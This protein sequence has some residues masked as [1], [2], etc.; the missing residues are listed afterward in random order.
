MLKLNTF[1]LEKHASSGI[2]NG[3]VSFVLFTVLHH[4]VAIQKHPFWLLTQNKFNL[5][6]V[7]FLLD[8]TYESY[9]QEFH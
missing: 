7:I 5:P 1:L 4:L 2:V 6:S 3:R 8:K 9:L